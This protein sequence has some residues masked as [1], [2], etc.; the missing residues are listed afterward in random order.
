MK[1][2]QQQQPNN[3]GNKSRA[4]SKDKPKTNIAYGQLNFSDLLK[5]KKD[6]KLSIGMPSAFSQKDYSSII[7][8]ARKHKKQS[9]STVLDKVEVPQNEKPINPINQINHDMKINRRNFRLSSTNESKMPSNIQLLKKLCERMDKNAKENMIKEQMIYFDEEMT[10]SSNKKN[11]DRITE[12]PIIEEKEQNHYNSNNNDFNKKLNNI[13]FEEKD[14]YKHNS[15][16]NKKNKEIEYKNIIYTNN[17]NHLFVE[18][19]IT[20]DNYFCNIQGVVLNYGFQEDMNIRCLKSMEDK[21][22]SIQNFDNDRNQILFELFDGHGGSDVSAFLQKNFSHIY[23]QIL[24]ESQYNIVKSLNDAFLAADEEIKKLPNIENMGATGT[25]V[26]IIWEGNN[27]IVIYTGNVGD[28]RV[29]LISS[30]KIIRL[31]QDHRA[32]DES[33]RKRI[34]AEGGIII[35]NRVSGEL[36]LTRSFG[37]FQFKNDKKKI[38]KINENMFARRGVICVPSV[39]K[40]EIDLNIKNQYLFLASDGIW[41][42]ISEKEL[43][44]LIKINNETQHL[45]S[46]I[47][48]NANIKKSWD[49]MSIFVVKLT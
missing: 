9:S 23:K 29:S 11:K 10:N 19:E 2:Q 37:D 31:S 43:Q 1:N 49:N 12:S 33:E 5:A 45:P 38:N 25:I 35:N 4:E 47:I 40:I 3:Q 41:D 7:E 17:R 27:R 18:T 36:M 15:S 44:Q 8:I 21:S 26:H 24:H 34:I 28:S 6:D 13:D 22:K 39:T 48:D 20:K 30:S 14:Y 42:V 16:N 46:I 32:S